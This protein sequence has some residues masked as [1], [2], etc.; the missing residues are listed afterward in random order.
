MW[1]VATVATKTGKWITEQRFKILSNFCSLP[2][3]NLKFKPSS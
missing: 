2:D 1:F 3:F